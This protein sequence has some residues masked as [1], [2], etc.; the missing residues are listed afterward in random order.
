MSALRVGEN[1]STWSNVC[2]HPQDILR[3]YK[4][5]GKVTRLAIY[6][7]NSISQ[8]WMVFGSSSKQDT[9]N[10]YTI[11]TLNTEMKYSS[12]SEFCAI[13]LKFMLWHIHFWSN[14]VLMFHCFHAFNIL[15]YA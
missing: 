10:S 2:A 12:L 5:S 4:T 15:K 8:M 6:I 14:K 7:E 3:W 1:S 11:V 9:E 13:E